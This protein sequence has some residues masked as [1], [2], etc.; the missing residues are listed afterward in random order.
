MK[1]AGQNLNCQKCSIPL[2][3]TFRIISVFGVAA[4]NSKLVKNNIL[5][6]RVEI[7][8]DRAYCYIFSLV[9][10]FKLCCCVYIFYN[11]IKI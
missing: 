4:V 1:V 2:L 10:Y 3:N 6:N 5:Y 11:F 9:Y 7:F 8:N